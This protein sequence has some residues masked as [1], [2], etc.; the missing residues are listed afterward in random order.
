M[1]FLEAVHYFEGTTKRQRSHAI[2]Q[3]MAPKIN[4]LQISQ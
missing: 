1:S 3:Q 4:H 2:M